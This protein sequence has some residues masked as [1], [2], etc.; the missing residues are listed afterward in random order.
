MQGTSPAE[1]LRHE[2]A[3]T[4]TQAHRGGKKAGAI[5]QETLKREDHLQTVVGLDTARVI[6]YEFRSYSLIATSS[7][8]STTSDSPPITKSIAQKPMLWA[9]S[10]SPLK[11]AI[12]KFRE[13]FVGFHYT[14]L[15]S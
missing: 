7:I 12:N 1:L 3:R 13:I 6:I 2:L 9:Y 14:I 4:I 5:A 10:S 15:N 8:A 11:R